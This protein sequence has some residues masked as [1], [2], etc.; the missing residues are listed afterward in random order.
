MWEGSVNA[1]RAY[2]LEADNLTFCWSCPRKWLGVG[3]DTLTG[4]K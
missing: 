2:A 3:G 1:L 4:A